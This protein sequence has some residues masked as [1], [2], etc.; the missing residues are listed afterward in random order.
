MQR[1]LKQIPNI[2]VGIMAHGDYC[3][4][5]NY[6]LRYVDLTSDV[7]ALVTFVRDVKSTGGGDAPEVNIIYNFPH[8]YV[9]FLLIL[10]VRC[11]LKDTVNRLINEVPHI[12]IGLIAHGDYLDFRT[13]VVNC[14]DF[15]TDVNALQTFV[16]DA[17]RTMGG[18]DGGEVNVTSIASPVCHAV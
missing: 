18:G 7:D 15:T 4:Q 13:Y 3:D 6:V 17:E 10:K 5:G 14:Q 2:R 12:R 11:R 16:Q 9:L 1:L 8:V